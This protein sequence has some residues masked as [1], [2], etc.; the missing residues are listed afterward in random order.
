MFDA[1]SGNS[2]STNLDT[3]INT[4]V[5]RPLAANVVGLT[6]PLPPS[7]A[8]ASALAVS[9][10]VFGSGN[11]TLIDIGAV[12][13]QQVQNGI[14][15]G[16]GNRVLYQFT[17]DTTTDLTLSLTG[18]GGDADLYLYRDGQ[19]TSLKSS[20]IDGNQ[21]SFSLSG[22]AAGTYYA[23][24]VEFGNGSTNYS[25][26]FNSDTA[27]STFTTARNVG[28]L[29]GSAT[30]KDFVGTGDLQD[31]YRVQLNGNSNTLTIALKDIAADADLYLIRDA[32]NNGI[33][34]I[35]ETIAVSNQAG[36]ATE[37][38]DQQ[39]LVAGSYYIG[40]SS[41]SGN[42]NYTLN[43]ATVVATP[44]ATTVTIPSNAINLGNLSGRVT[45]SDTVNNLGNADDFYRFTL[46]TAGNVELSLTG[47]GGDADLF[48][49]RDFNNDGRIDTSEIVRYSNLIGNQELISVTGLA[50]GTYYAVVEQSIAATTNYT[51]TASV[52]MAGSSFKD[53]RNLGVL[54][55]STTSVKDF[56]GTGDV[57][58]TYRFQVNG[59][60]NT[61]TIA[62][63]DLT[64]DADIYVSQDLNNNGVY[65]VGETIA[66]SY[67]A[68]STSE[69]LYLQGLSA[70]TYYID[71][72]QYQGDTNY[73]LEV[74]APVNNSVGLADL[75]TIG[76]PRTVS[77]TLSA[78]DTVDYY[79]FNL[80]TTSN[81]TLN[82]TGLT[83]SANG[84]LVRDNNNNGIWDAADT[85]QQ[86]LTTNGAVNVSN[87]PG[88]NYFIAMF[89]A[90]AD[91]NYNLTLTPDAAGNSLTLARSVGGLSGNRTF[92]DSI[93][94]QT[95]A[96]DYY[97]FTLNATS[98]VNVYLGGL[99][100]NL[101]LA[102]IQD[103]N[104]NGI[105]DANDSMVSSINLGTQADQI[106]RVLGPGTYYVQVRQ[107]NSTTI[108]SSAYKLDLLA[109]AV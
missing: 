10:P 5:L 60:N 8:A 107:P 22:L 95:D 97:R 42:T 83:N 90:T 40:V 21:E 81:L 72:M 17:I 37:I 64:A 55:S 99:A 15:V 92:I 74:A 96:I 29:T 32:N 62:L 80:D 9:P 23:D 75:G 16:N 12:N 24:V 103:V 34:D 102:L 108:A 6:T 48:L 91:T 73:T 70:G 53:A 31:F 28:L 88:G 14:V 63:K 46:T 98:S 57:R 77:G 71:V 39:N 50:A 58:D 82:L 87:L 47:V 7:T 93:N 13:G 19:T 67:N 104:N 44:P 54:N 26:T 79:R 18:A 11:T 2:T 36:V 1:N 78:S 52:D 85:I 84:F 35:G 25:L 86:V 106:T 3:A 101:D 69:T 20:A 4:Q 56:V 49:V 68:G 100:N 76:V 94:G 45:V 109:L 59:N 27:G 61:V 43:V 30:V 38:I 66:Y 41:Y 89:R 105:V 33:W 65:D 51:L